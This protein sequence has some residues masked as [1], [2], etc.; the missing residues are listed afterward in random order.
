MRLS[1]TTCGWLRGEWRGNSALPS[2][3]EAPLVI[4][5]F[6]GF[7]SEAFLMQQMAAIFIWHSKSFVSRS[8]WVQFE[9]I[10]ISRCPY[11]QPAL[12]YTLLLSNNIS[13]CSKGEEKLLKQSHAMTQQNRIVD[14]N[15]SVP[16]VSTVFNNY[17]PKWIDWGSVV[18]QGFLLL[19]KTKQFAA[20]LLPK[21]T[22][23]FQSIETVTTT[24]VTAINNHFRCKTKIS[25]WLMKAC[26]IR[27][28]FF[29]KIKAKRDWSLYFELNWFTRLFICSS[30][31]EAVDSL[32]CL[33]KR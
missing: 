25:F 12:L 14:Q 15:H 13:L 8:H 2:S 4:I 23:K 7:N 30:E 33:I 20:L 6:R 31:Y 32:C 10:N 11:R 5:F 27:L 19:P 3:L 26:V 17:L 16:L 9:M 18:W 29:S 28:N 21:V 22:I 1:N 24:T